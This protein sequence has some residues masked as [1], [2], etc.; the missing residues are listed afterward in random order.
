MTEVFCCLIGRIKSGAS[1]C[2]G[3]SAVC[4]CGSW[5]ARSERFFQRQRESAEKKKA[6]AGVKPPFARWSWQ[7]AVDD[8]LVMFG[9]TSH[10]FESPHKAVEWL[11]QQQSEMT[12]ALADGVRANSETCGEAAKKV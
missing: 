12:L 3:N 8:A 5:A 2:E 7:H 4:E 9:K 11:L 10:E 1:K 6:S